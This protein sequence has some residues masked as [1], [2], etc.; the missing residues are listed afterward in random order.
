MGN[1]INSNF[2]CLV[3]IGNLGSD[4]SSDIFGSS[5]FPFYS[6]DKLDNFYSID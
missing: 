6:L 5:L 1:H 2:D 3:D 4:R